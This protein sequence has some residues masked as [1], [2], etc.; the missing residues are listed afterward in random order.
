M[1]SGKNPLRRKQ[2]KAGPPIV[3]AVV[4]HLPDR[5]G[6]HAKRLQVIKIALLSIRQNAGR[7]IHVAVFDNGSCD[8]L[9]DWLI[10]DYRPESLVLSDNVGKAAA[11]RC[12][13][14]MFAPYT[15]MSFT[16][17]D[18]LHYPGWLDKQLDIL[19]RFPECVV[20][21]YPTRS[22]SRHSIESVKAW[23]ETE[24]SATTETGRLMPAA[25]LDD[26]LESVGLT[27][28]NHSL[29]NAQQTLITY[30]GVQAFAGS[31][32]CQVM[33]FIDTLLPFFELGAFDTYTRSENEYFDRPT[34]EAGILRLSTA[35]RYTR[36]IGNILEGSILEAVKEIGLMEYA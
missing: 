7:P 23:I 3:A 8:D 26:Y 15:I 36:H 2:V 20:T 1:R 12:L 24:P 27:E 32:H 19:D 21:G 13:A 17:D 25:W 16:D 18:M 29:T 9:R 33:G 35:E 10:N 22:Q 31:H 11:Q 14:H 30:K 5:R 6:Y 28:S 34:D 4:T